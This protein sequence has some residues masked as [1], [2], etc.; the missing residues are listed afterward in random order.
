M[1]GRTRPSIV[2]RLLHDA[3]TNRIPFNI[4]HHVPEIRIVESRRLEPSLKHMT[5]LLIS[6]IEIPCILS[7]NAMENFA[8]G[9]IPVWNRDVMDVV[10]HQRV[11]PDPNVMIET[12]GPEKFEVDV[13]I[14]VVEKDVCLSVSAMHDVI[15]VTGEEIARSSCHEP[16]EFRGEIPRR[17]SKGPN[18]V[19]RKETGRNLNSGFE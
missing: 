1:G 5:D 12:L 16:S 15:G 17:N 2:F 10:P 4:C 19:D 6:G 14:G 11:S 7:E 8:D 3:C 9:A 18:I 13:A